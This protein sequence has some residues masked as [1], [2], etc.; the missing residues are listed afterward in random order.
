MCRLRETNRLSLVQ[1]TVGLALFTAVTAS[2]VTLAFTWHQDTLDAYNQLKNVTPFQQIM[3]VMVRHNSYCWNSEGMCCLRETSHSFTSSTD[4]RSSLVVHA[5]TVTLAFA[6]HQDT[7]DSYVNTN[8]LPQTD[9]STFFS[10]GIL[11]NLWLLC[12]CGAYSM[13]SS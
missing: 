10:T 3:T 13:H 7:L 12:R 4:C 2:T 11:S 1:L 6:W 8:T 9:I 5:S